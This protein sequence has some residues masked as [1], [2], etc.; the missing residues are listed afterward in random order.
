M[1]SEFDNFAVC[2]LAI[3][4]N[5]AK[6]KNVW[7]TNRKSF[8]ERQRLKL[9]DTTEYYSFCTRKVREL[10]ECY[11]PLMSHPTGAYLA[12]DIG[13]GGVAIREAFHDIEKLRHGERP[14]Y[15]ITD[16]SDYKHSDGLEGDHCLMMVPFNSAE[17]RQDLYYGGRKM[18]EDGRIKF[19]YWDTIAMEE[20]FDADES[21]R[22]KFINSNLGDNEL[23]LYDTLEDTYMEIQKTIDELCSIKVTRTSTGVEQFKA[24]SKKNA[25][26]KTVYMH[27]DRATALLLAIYLYKPYLQVVDPLETMTIGGIV[28]ENKN[29]KKQMFTPSNS[30]AIKLNQSAN[31]FDMA[32]YILNK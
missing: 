22:E 32:N 18:L 16:P 24:E 14:I 30:L 27:K 3:Y 5:H 10:I 7:T 2:V 31:V 12:C 17:V 4:P 6:I 23:I 21:Q 19:P 1:A 26:G 25:E 9:T 11:P 20:A 28:K 15:E 29:R 8:E 13:G